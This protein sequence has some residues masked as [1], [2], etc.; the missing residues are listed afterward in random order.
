[1]C[2]PSNLETPSQIFHC[3]SVPF[4][5]FMKSIEFCIQI[6]NILYTDFQKQF[7]PDPYHSFYAVLSCPFLFP[8]FFISQSQF[9]TP[10]RE[11]NICICFTGASSLVFTCKILCYCFCTLS[12]TMPSLCG[13]VTN[14]I[15]YSR[16]SLT[17]LQPYRLLFCILSL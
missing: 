2:L 7:I 11:K 14:T 9:L 15:Q 8:H 5:L 6:Q 13:R 3:L 1:M 12:Q 16:Q 10:Y 17:L 4:I